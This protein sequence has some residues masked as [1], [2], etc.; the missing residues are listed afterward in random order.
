MCYEWERVYT[1]RA[2]KFIFSSPFVVVFRL[3]ACSFVCCLV[4]QL[5]V[6]F[7]ARFHYLSVYLC[8]IHFFSFVVFLLLFCCCGVCLC[9][10]L[11]SHTKLDSIQCAFGCSLTLICW[12]L[13][14][15]FSSIVSSL[16]L[17]YFSP[18]YEWWLYDFQYV[19]LIP[20]ALVFDK[21]CVQYNA[22]MEWNVMNNVSKSY[23]VYIKWLTQAK[24]IDMR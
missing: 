20:C 2:H 8:F 9:A 19:M 5:F 15:L 11:R 13:F 21:L 3:F 7:F 17:L 6:F 12:R 16:F 18:N 14:A 22:S 24:K 4:L 10:A 1:T 23:V